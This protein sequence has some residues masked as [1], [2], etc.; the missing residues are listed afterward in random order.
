MIISPQQLN[1]EFNQIAAI[2]DRITPIEKVSSQVRGSVQDLIV[3]WQ[4]LYY[5]APWGSEAVPGARWSAKEQ[6]TWNAALETYKKLVNK[7]AATPG[8]KIAAEQKVGS[9]Q[10]GKSEEIVVV[11]KR[12]WWYI[13]VPLAAFIAYL[14]TTTAK[15]PVLSETRPVTCTRL[16]IR[17]AKELQLRAML[18]Y[19][20]GRISESEYRYRMKILRHILVSCKANGRWN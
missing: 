11:G 6:D 1:D 20:Y 14:A 2:Y 19:S 3:K 8:V 4:D 17:K 5:T 7:A 16:Q 12:P 10:K 15:N 9:D 18:Q 13:G